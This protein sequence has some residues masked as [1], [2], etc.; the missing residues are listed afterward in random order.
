[1]AYYEKKDP[2]TGLAPKHQA[3][4]K[5][6][7]GKDI[8]NTEIVPNEDEA[9]YEELSYDY[10]LEK[11]NV[12]LIE[13]QVESKISDV[14]DRDWGTANPVKELTFENG[15]EWIIF[16][17]EDSAIE[18]ATLRVEEDVED[19]P[20][21]FPDWLLFDSID[22]DS[23]E[24]RFREMYDGMNEGYVDGIEDEDDDE[25]TN[26]LARE[27]YERDL[28]DYEEATDE[29][30]NLEDKKEDMVDE[31]TKEAIDEGN[32]GFDY[33]KSNFGTEQASQLLKDWMIV[34]TRKVAEYVVNED[35]AGSTLS[36]YDGLQ[37]DLDNGTV[38]FRTN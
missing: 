29:D 27:M 6:A 32:Y 15:E 36:G 18:A 9:R 2:E 38:M 26:R 35:G 4:A 37:V 17:D 16:D 28:I 21:W 5:K 23:A 8:S 24:H 25:F 12:K 20:E 33:Y 11:E 10:G 7:A 13:F 22:R 14:E 19:N 3:A 34:D 1:M 30:F 31:M